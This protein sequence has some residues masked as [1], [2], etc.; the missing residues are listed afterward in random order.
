MNATIPEAVTKSWENRHWLYCS[1][2]GHVAYIETDDLA[3]VRRHFDEEWQ[4]HLERRHSERNRE[5]A[6]DS[7]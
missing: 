7:V 1:D 4:R 6:T 5:R 3:K 2:H